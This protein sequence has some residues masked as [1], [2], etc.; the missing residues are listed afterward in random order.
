MKTSLIGSKWRNKY[1]KQ[2][3]IIKD[4]S[5]EGLICIITLLRG[6]YTSVV[7]KSLFLKLH[8]MV[9]PTNLKPPLMTRDL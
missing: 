5:Q 8:E 2:E 9:T 4:I 6:D 1:S 3:C 7:E